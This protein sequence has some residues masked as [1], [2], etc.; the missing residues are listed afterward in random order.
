M[1]YVEA[2]TEVRMILPLVPYYPFVQ[3]PARYSTH[4]HLYK[5]ESV[6]PVSHPVRETPRLIRN[7][8]R[9]ILACSELS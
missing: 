2:E 8:H 3:A 7:F 6:L 9:R 1:S 4:P 5:P